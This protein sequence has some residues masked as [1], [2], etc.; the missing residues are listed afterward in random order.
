M[1]L[2]SV[3]TAPLVII[4]EDTPVGEGGK[5]NLEPIGWLIVDTMLRM[6][7]DATL[8]L[9]SQ[10]P[11]GFSRSV[12]VDYHQS[13]T[14]RIKD[15]LERALNPEQ[16]IVGCE[17]PENPLPEPYLE[18]LQAFN[19]PIH[20]VSY[21]TAEFSKIAINMMLAAQ[22]DATNELSKAAAECGVDWNDVRTI[23]KHDKRIGTY[24]EPGDWKQSKH[25]LRDYV[26]LHETGLESR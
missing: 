4:A 12:G 20:Q 14:L 18:F 6:R 13:E 7:K 25:L 16:M 10:V 11:P 17:H 5:R 15:A 23:L 21:E 2:G 26:W 1:V 19:C 8:V 9:T 24:T 3:E 22:V